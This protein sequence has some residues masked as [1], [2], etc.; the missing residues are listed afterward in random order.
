VALTSLVHLSFHH[1][2][3][4]SDTQFEVAFSEKVEIADEFGV[5]V[6]TFKTT[7]SAPEGPPATSNSNSDGDEK[8]RKTW[9]IV[10]IVLAVV[11]GLGATALV[12]ASVRC[13]QLRRKGKARGVKQKY[14]VAHDNSKQSLG[15]VSAGP[16]FD[17]P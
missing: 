3:W 10:G 16:L 15:E 6:P 4:T 13:I 2:N 17:M 11:I 9:L 12:V 1:G 8:T 5:S 14:K 7:I